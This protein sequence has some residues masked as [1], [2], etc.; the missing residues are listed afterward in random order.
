MLSRACKSKPEHLRGKHRSAELRGSR[1]IV[2]LTAVK[3]LA[4]HVQDKAARAVQQMQHLT[5][6]DRNV[7]ATAHTLLGSERYK[8]LLQEWQTARIP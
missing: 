7:M 4:T 3:P 5:V 2:L 8:D 1:S 6:R